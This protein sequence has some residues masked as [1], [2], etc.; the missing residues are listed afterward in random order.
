[1]HFKSS[2]R[3]LKRHL[4]T[5]GVPRQLWHAPL[6]APEE[7]FQEAVGTYVLDLTLDSRHQVVVVVFVWLVFFPEHCVFMVKLGAKTLCRPL[8][9]QSG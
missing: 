2:S 5:G 7:D 4:I 3:V 9:A 1:M 8:Y 6:L